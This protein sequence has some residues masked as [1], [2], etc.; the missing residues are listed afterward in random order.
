[1]KKAKTILEQKLGFGFQTVTYKAQDN[2]QA[3]EE[4]NKHIKTYENQYKNPLAYQ[5]IQLMA[6]DETLFNLWFEAIKDSTETEAG[7]A[8]VNEAIYL[9]KNPNYNHRNPQVVHHQ[10]EHRG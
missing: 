10:F 1:M 6:H 8:L 9:S 3:L 7:F 5:A 2:K 4:V